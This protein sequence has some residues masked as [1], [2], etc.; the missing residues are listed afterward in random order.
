MTRTQIERVVQQFYEKARSHPELGPIFH[1]HVSDWTEHED[2][3]AGFWSNAI[4]H[5]RSYSGNPMQVHIAAGNVRSE[6][7]EV[8]LMLFDSVLAELLPP[9]V[10]MQWSALAHRIGRGLSSGL[11]M[12]ASGP[13]GV[14]NLREVGR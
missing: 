11:V 2:K 7:F 12:H 10:A 3:I 5:E 6:H 8:W 13:G 9:D 4:L 14:P 1:G